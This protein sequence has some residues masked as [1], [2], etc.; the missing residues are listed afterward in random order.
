MKLRIQEHLSHTPGQTIPMKMHTNEVTKRFVSST[1][2]N[3]LPPNTARTLA[4]T[5]FPAKGRYTHLTPGLSYISF[6]SIA[7]LL[8]TGCKAIFDEQTV[9]I[10]RKGNSIIKLWIDHQ[11]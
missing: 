1:C 4:F 6:F 3:K 9:N 10:T 2:G 5:K 7:K 11:T 8:D